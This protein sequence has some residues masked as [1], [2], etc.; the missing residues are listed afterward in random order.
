[1]KLKAGFCSL[2]LFLTAIVNAVAQTTVP[3]DD[4]DPDASCPLDT[5]VI[6]LVVV[7]SAFAAYSLYRKQNILPRAK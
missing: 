7:A 2:V 1:M 3:C 6:V 4:A 5:W